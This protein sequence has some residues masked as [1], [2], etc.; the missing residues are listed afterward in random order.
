[1]KRIFFAISVLLVSL[2]PLFCGASSRIS[3][4]KMANPPK[5]VFLIGFDGLSA[6]CLNNGAQMPAFRKI[7]EKGAYTLE[8]RSVLPSSSAVNWASMFMGAGPEL[9][10]YTEWGSKTPELPS[11][12][13]TCHNQFPDIYFLLRES[14][15]KAELGFFYEWEGMKYV[16][17]TLSVSCAKQVSLVSDNNQEALNLVTSYIKEKTPM[18]CSVILNEPDGAG[19]TKGWESPEYADMLVRVDNVLSKIVAAIDEA[20]IREESVIILSADHGGLGKGHGGKTMEEMQT[21]IVFQGKGIKKGVRI[22]E[23][24][25]VYDIAGTLGY[26]LG[27]GQPQVWIARPIKSVFEE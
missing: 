4:N 15:P 26:I 1:M 22:T 16:I 11:R 25:M 7:M 6:R 3:E 23:S 10:G 9:H 21:P 5:H 24:T 13:L 14:F 17:D 2:T 18:F 19:H 8:N 20:G 27:V 12:V